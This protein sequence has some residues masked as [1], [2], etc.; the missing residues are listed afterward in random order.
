M[1]QCCLAGPL[2]GSQAGG[3]ELKGIPIDNPPDMLKHLK[4]GS[5]DKMKDTSGFPGIILGS[6]VAQK[7]GMLLGSVVNVI[8][9][10]GSN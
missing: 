3:A 1:A 7:T 8:V 9:P 2:G 5:F 6:Q 4:Q 10:R